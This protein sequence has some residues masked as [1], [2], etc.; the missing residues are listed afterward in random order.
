MWQIHAMLALDTAR[1]RQREAQAW[2]LARAAREMTAEEVRRHGGRPS[3]RARA[4]AAH[5]LRR[6]SGALESGSR[7]ACGA[8]ARLDG[9]RA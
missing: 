5:V 2:A 4:A 7:A 8:A 9:S 1:E 6:L 3:G